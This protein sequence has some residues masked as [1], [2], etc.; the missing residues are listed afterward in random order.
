MIV[1]ESAGIDELDPPYVGEDRG[2]DSESDDIGERVE[3]PAEIADGVGQPCDASVQ[4]VEYDRG[5]N[6]LGACLK[7]RIGS[8]FA[9][10][11]R[12]CALERRYDC[13]ETEKDVARREQRRQS[14]SGSPRCAGRRARSGE[15][16]LEW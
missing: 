16:L 9:P 7:V 15:P 10:S 11:A 12:Q 5:S 13:D 2:R 14:V 6:R 8:E 3:F 1:Q 4:S